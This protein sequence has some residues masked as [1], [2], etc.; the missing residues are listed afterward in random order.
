MAAEQQFPQRTSVPFVRV[1]NL[2]KSYARRRWLSGER[3]VVPALDGVSL[4]ICAATTLALVGESGSGKST[5]ARCLIRLDEPDSGRIWFHGKDL[6]SLNAE[7]LRAFRQEVQL[8]FQDPASALNPRLSA[9]EIVAEPL[10]VQRRGHRLERRKKAFELMEQVGLAWQWAGRSP[11]E[12]SGG[13]RQR[14]AIARA[15]ALEPKLLILDEAL[16]AL[17]LAI[18]AQVVNLLLEL[19]A[20][21][22]LAYLFITHDLSLVGHLA[23]E[24][25]VMQHGR[26]VE[27][28]T[29]PELLHQPQH[30]HSRALVA[31][32]SALTAA[33]AGQAV[34]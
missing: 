24:V 25:A 15:L 4:T 11:A 9:E 6:L 26:I 33:A 23:D 5:L 14:L 10:V 18:Q 2:Y 20:L 1:E 34:L 12:F 31:A 29:P 22:G 19:Q 3:S 21:R 7:E 16:S 8:I 13:Q 28:A 30:P 27:R 32:M 17:D